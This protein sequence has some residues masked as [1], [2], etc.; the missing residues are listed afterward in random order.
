M[1][2]FCHSSAGSST[3]LQIML[4]EK[5]FSCEGVFLVVRL[6]Q[7]CTWDQEVL[8]EHKVSLCL[9]PGNTEAYS[10]FPSP[11]Q[12]HVPQLKNENIFMLLWHLI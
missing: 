9:I 2:F 6:E 4:Q 5:L 1:L 11:D 7:V 10:E 12:C 3:C 8:E